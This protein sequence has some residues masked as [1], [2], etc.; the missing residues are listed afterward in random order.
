[1]ET[2]SHFERHIYFYLVISMICWGISWPASKILTTYSDPYTLMFLKFF[3]S[4]LALI[5]MLY[6]LNIKNIFSPFI[7][8]PL[9]YATLFIIAY[10]IFF[11]YGL[12]NGFAGIGGVIVTGSNPI[13]IFIIVSF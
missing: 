9:F 6:F 11:F 12:K 8:K 1:M 4:S 5:P 2:K 13:F 3:I 10:N 7:I